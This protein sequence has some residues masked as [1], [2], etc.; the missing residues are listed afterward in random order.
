MYALLGLTAPLLLWGTYFVMAG[1]RPEYS[2]K[3]KAISELGSL[4]APNAVWWNV[5]G[6]LLPGLFIAAFAFGFHRQDFGRE[7]S[8]VPMIGLMLSGLLMS[9]AGIFP[10][11]MEHREA[12]TSLLHLLGSFGSYIA[13]L[14]AAFTYPRLWRR[15]EGW[16]AM[17][18][19]G[20]IFTWL[21]IAFGAW[22]M[23]F[24]QMPAVGQRVVFLCYSLWIVTCAVRML[25]ARG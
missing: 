9:F 4:D 12:T 15:T 20:R 6:Y 18:W 25:R 23:V 11:D 1:M 5:L 19:P 8:K 16:Q 10:D 17:I 3:Y 2:F 22:P 13:F 7:S 24:P 21:S 14:V